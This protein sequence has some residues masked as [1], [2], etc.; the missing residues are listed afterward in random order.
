M[1]NSRRKYS[2]IIEEPSKEALLI[3]GCFAIALILLW[4]GAVIYAL[5]LVFTG[6]LAKGLAILLALAIISAFTK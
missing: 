3:V 5:V 2:T 1:S 4:L 6:E